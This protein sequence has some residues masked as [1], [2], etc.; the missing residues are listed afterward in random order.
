MSSSSIRA[1][2]RATALAL[3]LFIP[4]GCE[5]QHAA[6]LPSNNVLQG[7]ARTVSSVVS[8]GG[9]SYVIDQMYTPY[10]SNLRGIA[11]GPQGDIWFTGD[12]L[13]GRST[14]RGDMVDF[15][16][17]SYSNATSIVDGP[18]QDLWVTLYPAA[19]GRV[20]P[21][22]Y[23]T[24]F[25]IGSKLGGAES[26]PFSITNGPDKAL[27]FVTNYSASYIVR[28]TLD[29][30][31]SGY[32]MASGSR[33]QWL[34]L[35]DDGNLWFTDSG[36]NKIGTMSAVGT[37]KEFSVP[38]PDAG[39]SG[40]CQ[41]PDGKLWFIEQYANKVGSVTTS[42]SFNE[43]NIPTPSTD[44][45]SI[46]AGPD[47]AL[48]FTEYSVGKI[49]R[50]TTS[51]SIV[52]MQLSG[53]YPRP[54]DIAVGSDKNLWFTESESYGIV[55]RVELHDVKGS[56]PVYAEIAL[57][58]GKSHAQLGVSE[59]L[60]LSITVYNLNH[61]V[62]TG[63]YPNV[64]HLATSDSKQAALSQTTVTSSTSKASVLFSGDYTD[65]TISANANGGAT[66]DPATI[67]P[68]T[69]REKKLPAPGYGLTQGPN[70]S[71]WICLANGSIA[72][73][74]MQG[75]VRVYHATTS[76]KEGC[77]IVEADGN[78]W[79]TDDS[80]NRIGKITPLGQV[81]FFALG[82]NGSPSSMT[83]GS[84]GALWFTEYFP[85][86]IGRLTTGG[87]LS[88]YVAGQAPLDIVSGPDGNLWY[89]AGAGTIYK[90]T[91]SGKRSRVRSV[92]EMGGLWS[93]EHNLWFYTASGMQLEE[94]ST[95]GEIVKKYTVP[96]DCLPFS[97]TSGPQDSIWY[98]DPGDDCAARMTLSGKFYVVPTY[99]QKQNPDLITTIVVGKDDDLWFTETGNSGLGWIDPAT[100]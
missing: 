12:A 95:S 77:S 3:S 15:V 97:L 23:L 99:S 36:T 11:P 16:M 21:N 26:N 47:G 89:S 51:G 45:V 91:T 68:S 28:I 96:V 30:D 98:V 35:G 55:G 54:Y 20:A 93:A 8:A 92:Y 4:A 38:T 43:Y 72:T 76:F 10:G 86:K 18:D 17:P 88:T 25:P 46:V 79:F 34:A 73:Y 49:G 85:G 24:A 87:A 58:L 64:I 37:V 61:H 44:P 57:S 75:A 59:K 48:W 6:L 9:R 56:A 32:R 66:I 39:L 84:D 52:E 40:I 27:W 69:P 2:S 41:G 50:I 71:L 53:T 22:G 70:D 100:M 74:S 14:I 65:A 62:M 83:L 5:A 1:R 29:G 82:A 67:L 60:P 19:I 13:V 7:Q 80:N 31:M 81:T 42:G 33:P 94:M 63:H 78:V 90:M